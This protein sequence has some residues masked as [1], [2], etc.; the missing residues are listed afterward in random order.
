LDTVRSVIFTPDGHR[1]ISASHDRTVRIWGA[2]PLSSGSEQKCLTLRGHIGEINSVAFSPQ[3]R[4]MAASAGSDGTVRFW[5]ARTGR[6]LRTLGGN[7]GPF[8][9]LAF[10]RAGDLVATTL[11]LD[12]TMGGTDQRVRV[13]NALTGNEVCTLPYGR[14]GR[15]LPVSFRAD[16]KQLAAAGYDMRVHVWDLATQKQIHELQGHRWLING[17]GFN[18]DGRLLASASAD[19]TV[20]VWDA[21]AGGEIVNPPLQHGGGVLG[22]AFSPDGGRLA[23]AGADWTVR[24]WDT[25]TWKPLH[26]LRDPTGA[27]RCVAFSPDGRRLAWGGTDATVKFWDEASGLVQTLRGHTGWVNGVAFSADGQMIASAS[28][29]GT[30]RVWKAPPVA[31]PPGGEAINP[32]P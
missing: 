29:D 19:G 30:V 18:P 10:S 12:L 17:V 15:P 26:I 5:D 8:Q 14:P 6:Q 2:T 32:D 13:W 20:R 4:C 16:G 27:V 31:E 3:D 23:S 9:G 25:T 1:L 11:S 21:M 22:V 24:V 28:A 7:S